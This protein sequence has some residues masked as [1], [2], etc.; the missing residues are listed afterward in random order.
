VRRAALIAA[1]ALAGCGGDGSDAET[2]TRLL[3]R[4]FAAD[5]ETGVIAL[6]AELELEGGTLEGPFR[7]ELEGPFRMA[8]DS[9]DVAD[10]D[11]EFAP[12]APAASTRAA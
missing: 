7:L 2:A 3:E 4:G 10:L 12:R 1:L 5:V 11:L 9:T 8:A 6:E